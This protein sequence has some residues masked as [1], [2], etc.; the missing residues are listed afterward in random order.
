MSGSTD[1]TPST[2]SAAEANRNKGQGFRNHYGAI[3][4]GR[5]YSTKKYC[6]FCDKDGHRRAEC[7]EFE[8]K[9]IADLEAKKAKYEARKAE[10][11]A[12][13]AQTQCYNCKKLGHLARDCSAPKATKKC[14]APT[15]QVPVK[16]SRT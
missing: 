6:D 2:S 7:E 4:I 10:Y 15:S 13:L 14:L 16:N 12:R 1:P 8:T 9:K 11:M 3:V 5:K